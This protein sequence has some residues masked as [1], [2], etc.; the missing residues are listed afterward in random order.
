MKLLLGLDSRSLVGL[1][2]DRHDHRFGKD[3]LRLALQ[4]VGVTG[5]NQQKIVLLDSQ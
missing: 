2:N 5:I 1:R 3:R 4:V